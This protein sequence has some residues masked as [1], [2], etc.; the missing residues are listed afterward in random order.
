MV[1]DFK[2]GS[3]KLAQ[4]AKCPIVPVALMDSYK[5]FNSDHVGPV[6]TYAYYMEP[7][8]YED[9]KSMKTKDIAKQVENQ[10]REKIK[11]HLG[12]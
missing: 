12:S 6:T 3:F 2:P 4:M 1:E 7:I 11:E 10:I 9:F 5:V 8:P